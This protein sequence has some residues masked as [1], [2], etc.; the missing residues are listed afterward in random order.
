MP[1]QSYMADRG[2]LTSKQKILVDAIKRGAAE[3]KKNAEIAQEL[4][5]RLVFTKAETT[6]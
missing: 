2:G 4:G 1:P 6:S 3:V 5:I